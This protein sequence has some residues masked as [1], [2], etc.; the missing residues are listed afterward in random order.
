VDD[1]RRNSLERNGGDERLGSAGCSKPKV[2]IR[3]CIS[4]LTSSPPSPH[5]DRVDIG[6]GA[7]V[8]VDPDAE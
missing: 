6:A 8:E 2:G 4:D 7:G 3:S 5:Q 1:G